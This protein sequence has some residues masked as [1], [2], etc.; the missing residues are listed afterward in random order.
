MYTRGFVDSTTYSQYI[1]ACV[2]SGS[3]KSSDCE[4]SQKKIDTDFR[5]SKANIYN[6][7]GVC[8]PIPTAK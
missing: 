5:S 7:Y 2:N 8:Y 6:V 1:S 3:E 4:A